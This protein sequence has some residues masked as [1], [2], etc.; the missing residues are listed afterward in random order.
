MERLELWN[1]EYGECVSL[2]GR[3][4]SVLMV[5]CGSGISELF[6]SVPVYL[7]DRKEELEGFSF[8]T[9]YFTCEDGKT[10]ERIVREYAF[11]GR[12]EGD[13]TRGLYYRNVL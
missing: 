11:G 12:P 8:L 6:N 4:G 2:L 5:D 10:C 7:A 3:D 1:M 9:L 13:K